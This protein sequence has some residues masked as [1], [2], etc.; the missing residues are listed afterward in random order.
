MSL[1]R[2]RQKRDF[3]RT[4]EPVESGKTLKSKPIFVIQKHDA[5]RLHFDLRLEMGGTLLSWAVPKGLPLKHGEK[6]LA[7]KVEDHPISYA[8]FEGVIPAGEYGG[9]TVMIWDQGTYTALG[10]SPARDVKAGK[11]HFVLAGKKLD[12]E[13]YLVRLREEDQW[14]VIRSGDDH[15][16]IP[17]KLVDVSVLSG[18]TLPGIAAT[19]KSAPTRTSDKVADHHR[20]AKKSAPSPKASAET[21]VPPMMA[22]LVSRVPEGNWEYEVKFDGYRGLALKQADH[23]SIYS[24][25]RHD[26]TAK[27]P[28]VAA[29]LGS[30]KADHALIDGELVALEPDGRSSFQL[31]QAFEQ[32]SEGPPVCYYAFDLLELDGESLTGWPLEK[33]KARLKKL[34]PRTNQ[35]LRFS[36]LLGQDAPALLEMTR[37]YRLEGLIGKRVASAYEPGKRTGTWI[38]LKQVAEQELVIG[39]YT[40][41]TGT[42]PHF[43][44]LLVGYY[45][46][47]KLC[48][49]GKVGT[50]FTAA[51]LSLL[52]DEMKPYHRTDCPFTPPPP[53]G[54]G[55]YGQGFTAAAL[56]ECHWLKPHLV[57]QVKFTEW[58][59]DG[60]L[61]HPVY[62]GLRRDKRAKDVVLE[63]PPAP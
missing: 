43:G 60:R 7:V 37:K 11:L 34:L 20:S 16:A 17:G 36:P 10:K 46:K 12:G 35:S 15:P 5:G 8:K 39:G 50:G 9:G 26:L 27:F 61:R 41:P 47:G 23:V 51:Q 49:A 18:K 13:W 63:T 57:A 29:A 2:Y 52:L 45:K 1:E 42:R 19:G 4:P 28:E 48:Y 40:D 24:R 56:R 14:L 59:R 38:K 55:R 44:A 32:G 30:L 31:L 53:V 21:W 3:A 33:R 22:R 58:T 6:R 62:T 25:T 54:R